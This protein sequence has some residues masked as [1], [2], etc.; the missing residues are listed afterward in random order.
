M[1][2]ICSKTLND[3][4]ITIFEILFIQLT[5][6]VHQYINVCSNKY[7][8]SVNYLLPLAAEKHI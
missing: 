8:S 2:K 6:I 4:I 7:L 5:L 3:G 1:L